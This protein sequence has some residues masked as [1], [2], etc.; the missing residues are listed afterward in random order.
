MYEGYFSMHETKSDSLSS[1]RLAMRLYL[2][3]KDDTNQTLTVEDM[4]EIFNNYRP[5]IEK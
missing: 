1:D 2:F 5:G 4:N 3:T